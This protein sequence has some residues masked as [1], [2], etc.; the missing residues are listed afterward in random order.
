MAIR[1][2]DCQQCQ[3]RF[4]ARDWRE[5]RQTKYCSRR[6]RD[7]AQTTRVELVCVQCSQPFRRKAYM[8]ERSTERGPFC[9]FDCYGAWQAQ[10]LLGPS[11]PT[12]GHETNPHGRGSH[13]WVR[14]RVAAL[15]RDR[16]CCVRCGVTGTRSQ[17]HVHH[18]VPWAEGQPDPHA[19]DNLETLCA[20]H[21]RQAHRLLGGT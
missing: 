21:H 18:I 15:E 9:G 7:L 8:A 19:L 1:W 6:C 20:R 10:N 4:E 16:R 2:V 5:N 12:W 3:V 11:S 14:N 17:I 13:R